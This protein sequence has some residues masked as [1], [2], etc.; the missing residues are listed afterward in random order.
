MARAYGAR[1]IGTRRR[2]NTRFGEILLVH[3]PISAAVAWTSFLLI[4]NIAVYLNPNLEV[5][6]VPL[7]SFYR[8]VIGVQFE[9]VE[10]E[11]L[12]A[13]LLMLDKL[14]KLLPRKLPLRS[15]KKP[16][17][18]DDAVDGFSPASRVTWGG[19]VRPQ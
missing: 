2:G 13:R 18:Q 1:R 6:S 17:P 14:L 4:L 12:K 19:M 8:Y 7:K 15:R 3:T 10:N 16:R 9:I 5:S 11:N